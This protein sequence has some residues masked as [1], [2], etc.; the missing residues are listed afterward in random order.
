MNVSS[1]EETKSRM[2]EMM[3]HE[4]GSLFFVLYNETSWL[5][6]QWLEFKELYGTKETRI[7]L[8]NNVAPF[9]FYTVQK[10]MWYQL[11]LGITRITDPM[12]SFGKSNAT[13]KAI[14]QYVED[15]KFKFEIKNDIQEIC[16]LSKFCRDWRNRVISHLDYAL[17]IQDNN[18]IPL[19]T[20]SREKYR[21]VLEKTH[22]LINKIHKKYLQS[23]VG[24]D[25]ITSYRGATS[26]LLRIEAGLWYDE[27]AHKSKLEGT[28]KWD[29]EPVSRV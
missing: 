21:I 18:V 4:F 11:L 9:F 26:L 15:D 20:S 3:G 19:E 29:D 28:W 8:M 25:R 10:V 13:F 27:L 23:Y 12:E 2:V 6:F 1:A 24:F 17:A 22:M 5:T 16:E 14:P 7:E